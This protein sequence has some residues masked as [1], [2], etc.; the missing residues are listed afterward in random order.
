M[1]T[2]AQLVDLKK[3]IADARAAYHSLQTGRQPRVVVDQN[4]ERVEFAPANL[5]R[6]YT[7]IMQLEAQL[8]CSVPASGVPSNGP[9]GFIF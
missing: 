4:G 2:A 5:A 8:P 1:L 3:Q 9:A 6:L 7:Y